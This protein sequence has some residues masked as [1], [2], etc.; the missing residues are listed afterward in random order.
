M[1]LRSLTILAAGFLSMVIMVVTP[2]TASAQ[3]IEK[4]DIKMALGWTF[5]AS[6]AMYIYG[7][8]KGFFKEEGL[9]VT[10]DRGSGSAAAVQRVAS[11]T[12][13]FG[14]A[15]LGTLTR[16]NAENRSRTVLA[17]YV[18]EDDSPL[19]LFSLQGKGITKPKDIEG[20]RIGVS[21]FDGARQ[22]LPVL[23]HA[24]KIDLSRLTLK[25][26]DSQLREIMLARGEVDVI[27]GFTISSINQLTSLKQQ[28]VVMRYKDFG[29]DGFG[30]ALI[31]SPEFA[32]K[33]PNTV[34]AFVRAL[35]R[36]IKAMIEN[37]KEALASLKTRDSLVDL[38][39]EARRLE[40]LLGQLILT[41]H[42]VKNGLSSPDPKRLAAVIDSVLQTTDNKAPLPV[43]SVYTDR[44]LPPVSERMPPAWHH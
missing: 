20:K 4:P 36:S 33:N 2:Q 27:T 3:A 29:V 28:F 13:Q 6:Q 39:G 7:V 18:A 15:D 31:V 10:V 35:N 24:N 32:Q 44:F 34:R 14:Y 21:Q 11:G 37:P 30:Q 40:L 19:A 26:V 22:M 16:H 1:K 17:V 9:N 5:I 25:T 23:A 41:P 38:D 12:Y 8:E 42:V 43:A